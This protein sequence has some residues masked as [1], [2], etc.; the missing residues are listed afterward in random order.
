MDLNK[1]IMKHALYNALSFKGK[2]NAKAVLGKVIS[3]NP[4][5]KEKLK[6]VTKKVEEIVKNVNKL[7]PDE[8]KK[9]LE[10]L[11]PELLEKKEIKRKELPELKDAI[12]G[13]VATRM[14]PEP[15]KYA[16]I[17]HALTFLINYLYAKKY[18]G[19]CILRFED[20]NP[21]TAAQEYV[22]A[23]KDD[24][25][26]LGIKPD[27]TVIVSNDMPTFY[28]FAEKLIKME[29]AYVCFCAREKMQELRQKGTECEC[30]AKQKEKN[31]EEWKNMLGKKYKE[32]ECTLRLKGNFESLNYVMR[33][34]V[35]FRICEKEH[36]LQKKK[37][38]AWP[39]YDFENAVEDDLCGIT[40]IMRSIEFGEMR[41]ELQDYIKEL[42]ELKKQT[43][44][45]YGRF[46][47]SGAI[48]QGREIRK[49]IQEKKVIGW[50]D[51]RLVTIKALRRRGIQ[52]EA[53]Y[54]LAVEV[55]LS[56]TATNIDWSVISAINRKILDPKCERYF[57][58]KEPVKIKIENAPEQVA[59]VKKHPDYPEWGVRK[60][61]TGEEFYIEKKD[62]DE[63]KEGKL[64]RLMDCLNFKKS[65]NRSVFDSLEYEKFRKEGSKIMHWLPAEG[66]IPVE[67]LM[68]DG[69]TTKGIAEP[70]VKNLKVNDIIQFTRFG[71]CRL[72]EKGNKIVFWYAHD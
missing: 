6:E 72:D 26:Y 2:A 49:L 3:E 36:F 16:H 51:P 5:L 28:K 23:I 10:K 31:L 65:K 9:Q 61:K 20:T 54:E 46:N 58:I 17:G 50:D 13:K 64:Y 56:T 27:K 4:E 35:I 43:I 68:P 55:G 53:L 48:T 47:V 11:A 29:K 15:S 71:F 67:V 38:A 37:Y 1:A 34:P 70:L 57:F 33:D 63:L 7:S 12:K 8:Q 44:I 40:H 24:V 25:S 21:E 39:M 62:Y 69:K 60:F 22:D 14:P 42:L 18:D 32:G 59:E 41:I 30:R 52:K 45:Q 19:K 66:N